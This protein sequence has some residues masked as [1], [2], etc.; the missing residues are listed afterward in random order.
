MPKSGMY[1]PFKTNSGYCQKPTLFLVLIY[2]V[3]GLGVQ[4][5]ERE[6]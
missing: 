6:N 3:V 2:S 5:G 1:S 4:E